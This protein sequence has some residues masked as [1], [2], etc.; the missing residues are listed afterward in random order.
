M[1]LKPSGRCTVQIATSSTNVIGTLARGIYA[2]TITANP[3][4][5]STRIVA[6]D[7]NVAAG[8]AGA[9]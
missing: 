3:P 6:H 5:N 4:S 9:R 1:E 7:N 8:T 2:P